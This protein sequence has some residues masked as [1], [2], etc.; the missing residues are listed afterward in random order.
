MYKYRTVAKELAPGH[1][2]RDVPPTDNAGFRLVVGTV[3]ISQDNAMLTYVY[4][5]YYSIKHKVTYNSFKVN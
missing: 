2:S 4:Q 3:V 1:P 5:Y